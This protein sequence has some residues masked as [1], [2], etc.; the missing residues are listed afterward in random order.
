MAMIEDIYEHY[1]KASGVTTDSRQLEE[2]NIF[3]ALK[4][5]NF[6]GNAY[7]HLALEKGADLVI[8]DNKQY[9]TSPKSI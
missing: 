6:D 1:L 5:D 9:D 8:I 2:N 7:A 4:G 3:F